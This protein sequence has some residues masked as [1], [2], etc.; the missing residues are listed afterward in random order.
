MTIKLSIIGQGIALAVPKHVDILAGPPAPAA[1]AGCDQPKPNTVAIPTALL[2]INAR[3][4][5]AR[6]WLKD[7]YQAAGDRSP[8]EIPE[9][10]VR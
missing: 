4:D 7:F 8:W 2:S 10:L 6:Q 3:D 9:G 5:L 1:P